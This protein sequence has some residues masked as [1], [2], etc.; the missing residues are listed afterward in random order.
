MNGNKLDERKINERF[1]SEND[2][3]LKNEGADQCCYWAC[4]T[5]NGREEQDLKL[6]T[7]T[8][9]GIVKYCCKEHQ[10]LDWKWE[11]KGEC[12][13]NLPEFLKQEIALDREKNLKG[14]YSE[15][16]GSS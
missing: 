7:C 16:T 6:M 15:N 4:K 8:G 1:L 9:C 3:F 5:P 13:L 12:T 14:D 11:H 2:E 10:K